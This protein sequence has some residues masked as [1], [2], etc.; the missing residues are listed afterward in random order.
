MAALSSAAGVVGEACLCC[1]DARA[2]CGQALAGGDRLRKQ[3][4]ALWARRVEGED[5]RSFGCMRIE[6]TKEDVCSVATVG[7]CMD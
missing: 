6:I 2:L 1:S 3:W 4:H 5:A 7:G